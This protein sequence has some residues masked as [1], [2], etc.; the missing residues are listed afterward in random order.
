MGRIKIE[1]SA[2]RVP[3]TDLYPTADE[4][5]LMFGVNLHYPS[6]VADGPISSFCDKLVRESYLKIYVPVNVTGNA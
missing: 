1:Y 6:I 5:G 2:Y 4:P 3:I